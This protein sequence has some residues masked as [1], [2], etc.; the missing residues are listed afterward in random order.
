MA[1]CN[2]FDEEAVGQNQQ[3]RGVSVLSSVFSYNTLG[4]FKSI[5]YVQ[6]I[7]S[8]LIGS[9]FKKKHVDFFG[10]IGEMLAFNFWL[11]DYHMQDILF[12]HIV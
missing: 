7:W 12:L 9:N 4:S 1:T 8:T 10:E 2:Y 11:S 6:N 3:R 5:E